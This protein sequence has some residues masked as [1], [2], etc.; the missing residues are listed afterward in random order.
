M[1]GK[2]YVTKFFVD[3]NLDVIF[4]VPGIH[5]LPLNAAAWNQNI[6]LL[7][8]R[9]ESSCA[10]MAD[11]YARATGRAGVVLVTPGPGLGNCVTGVLEAYGSDSPLLLIHVD[12]GR[13]EIGRG[14]LHELVEPENV[15]RHFIKGA[16]TVSR[17]GEL[18]LLFRKALAT[19]LSP[20]QGPVLLSLPYTFFEKEIPAGPATGGTDIEAP[21]ID[22]AIDRPAIEQAIRGKTRPVIIGGKSLMLPGIE[23]LLDR[24]CL[25]SSIPFL[26][27][28]GGKGIV[29]ETTPYA[30]GNIMQ[31]GL[32][33]EVLE[34]S[35][36]VIAIGTRLRDVDAK[37]RGV[38]I[39]QLIHIDIDNV[40]IGKN[41]PTG[42]K[43]TADLFGALKTLAEATD[44][45]KYEWDLADLKARQMA[46]AAQLA[47]RSP[48]FDAVASIRASIPEETTTVWDL[49]LIAYWAEYYFPVYRQ[50][51]FH[52]GRGTS[53]IFFAL[54]AAIGAK[55]GRPDRPCLAVC[56]DG[57]VLPSLAD[58]AT[59]AQYNIPVVLLIYNNGAYGILSDAMAATYGIDGAMKLTNPDFVRLAHSFGIRAERA[60]TIDQLRDV[61]TK[62]VSWAEPFVIDFTFPIFPPPW[63]I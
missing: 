29:P 9:H 47:G 41:Y 14:I 54:P 55:L 26:T 63:R 58:L 11:G 23:G 5:T 50:R 27:S 33:R 16:F 25:G 35:D 37:R 4:H 21:P 39:R 44:G 7:V 13:E 52:V 45:I 40:W 18:D 22:E 8:P 60:E 34:A 38:K 43:G 20:R 59:M 46:Q 32:V 28:T 62:R 12:T 49:N 53:P 56:G 31:K 48:G 30:L 2:Q 15:F 6:G 19:A 36:C 24:I 42:L 61:F 51:S 10:F 57:G 3:N 17:P 1:L